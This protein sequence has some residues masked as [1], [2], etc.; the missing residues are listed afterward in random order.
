MTKPNRTARP[1]STKVAAPKSRRPADAIFDILK[2]LDEDM[3]SM[4]RR[5]IDEELGFRPDTFGQEDPVDL[6]AE[7]I[8]TCR[9]G[10]VD[11]EEKDELLA[12]LAGELDELK[13]EFERRR[14]GRA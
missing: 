7:Y 8:E 3:V 4:L 14:P 11:E 1:S 12:D 13:L 5:T 10:N 2:N 9:L 6:F